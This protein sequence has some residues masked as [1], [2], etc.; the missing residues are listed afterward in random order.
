MAGYE[1]FL[2]DDGSEIFPKLAWTLKQAGYRVT[3]SE[4]ADPV[5][6]CRNMDHF[7]LMIARLASRHLDLLQEVQNFIKFNPQARVILLS[8]NYEMVFPLPVYEMAIDDYI[9]MPCAFGEL[10]R[11]LSACLV[12][13]KLLRLRELSST[14]SAI[15]NQQVL[16]RLLSRSR[17]FK[18]TLAAAMRSGNPTGS[19]STKW[20]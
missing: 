14:P 12:R 15:I 1:I 8:G 9:F 10:W 3:A 7:D 18:W 13:V 2:L 19:H 5:I 16:R 17:D 6:N 4:T 11:R 20:N